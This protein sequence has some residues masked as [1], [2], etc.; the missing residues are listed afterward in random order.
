MPENVLL[1]E[2]KRAYAAELQ[3]Q[4][5]QQQ[6]KRHDEKILNINDDHEILKRLSDRERDRSKTKSLEKKKEQVEYAVYL[7]RQMAERQDKDRLKKRASNMVYDY[8]FLDKMGENNKV[9]RAEDGEEMMKNWQQT[10]QDRDYSKVLKH[11]KT[12]AIDIQRG[13]PPDLNEFQP[14]HHYSGEESIG[15]LMNDS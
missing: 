3:S 12:L 10:H 5:I 4:M 1:Q 11:Q 14:H 13:N 2:K 15:R 6:S 9:L 8:S 7:Q